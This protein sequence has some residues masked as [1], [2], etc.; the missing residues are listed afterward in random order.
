MGPRPARLLH[1]ERQRVAGSGSRVAGFTTTTLLTDTPLPCTFTV[2][3]VVKL[4]PLTV[5]VAVPPRLPRFG[6][7]ELSVGLTGTGAVTVN[8]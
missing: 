3:G 7:S 1:A 2:A 5:T 8:D 4:A 6:V